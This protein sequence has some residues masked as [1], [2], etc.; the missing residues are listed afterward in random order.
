MEITGVYVPLE[1][2]T[3]IKR[4]IPDIEN[5]E[6]MVLWEQDLIDDS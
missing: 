3:L 6:D 2:W 4:I 1:D 5:L